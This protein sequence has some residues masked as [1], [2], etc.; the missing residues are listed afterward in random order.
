MT[1]P[2]RKK[3]GFFGKIF[4]YPWIPTSYPRTGYRIKLG[5]GDVSSI[6]CRQFYAKVTTR[7]FIT[8][9]FLNFPIKPFIS[10][11]TE[12]CHQIKYQKLLLLAAP[13]ASH[14]KHKCSLAQAVFTLLVCLPFPCNPSDFFRSRLM[15]LS[16]I[17]TNFF[18]CPSRAFFSRL[19]RGLTKI[20]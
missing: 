8:P 18:A 12:N 19:L 9:R 7:A 2:A 6:C 14:T 15:H 16:A 11:L 17:S 4:E 5:P 13:N 10:S 1:A 20:T 3:L